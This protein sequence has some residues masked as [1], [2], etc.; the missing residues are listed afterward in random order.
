M[1]QRHG[2]P[3]TIR[4]FS[5]FATSSSTGDTTFSVG[6]RKIQVT[7]DHSSLQHILTQPRLTP[8]QMR[9]LQDITEYDVDVKYLPGAK[10]NVQDALSR[11][12]DYQEP[13]LSRATASGRKEETR[14]RTKKNPAEE[15][16]VLSGEVSGEMLGEVEGE[17]EGVVLA[18]LA[19][20]GI[21]E[22]T[23]GDL[24]T[25]I[26]QGG[27]ERLQQV[28]EGYEWDLYFRDVLAM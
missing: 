15:L 11:R 20:F 12:P 6:G 3:L 25:L 13:P 1:G 19:S 7:T 23:H 24:F 17:G 22:M 26:V 18:G 2:M 10:N 27:E 16:R 9:A 4:N 14:R 28:R 21:T 8:R 5:L